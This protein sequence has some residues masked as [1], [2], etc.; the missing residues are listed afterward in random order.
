MNLDLDRCIEKV[1]VCEYLAEDE[2]KQLCDYVCAPPPPPRQA[3]TTC[4]LPALKR[5]AT[6]CIPCTIICPEL[7]VTSIHILCVTYPRT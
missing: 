7:Y 5:P 1:K 4:L 6:S 3:D 2:L